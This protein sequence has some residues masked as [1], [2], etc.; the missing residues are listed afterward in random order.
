[1][2]YGRTLTLVRKGFFCRRPVYKIHHTSPGEDQDRRKVMQVIRKH[3]SQIR[4]D[5]YS[6][7][8]S[9]R[10]P[11]QQPYYLGWTCKNNSEVVKAS[12]KI[13]GTT[14]ITLPIMCTLS[15][16]GLKCR[17]ASAVGEQEKYLHIE[18]ARMILFHRGGKNQRVRYRMENRRVWD[19]EF[20]HWA[21]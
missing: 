5:K 4:K 21:I 17:N 16:Q 13:N 10:N 6:P 2:V 19:S 11:H 12:W 3:N 8:W 9:F 18:R 14:K 20:N 15:S 7:Q 1:M